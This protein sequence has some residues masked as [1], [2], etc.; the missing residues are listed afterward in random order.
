MAGV[1]KLK[2][3]FVF[4]T[5]IAIG[6]LGMWGFDSQQGIKPYVIEGYSTGTNYNG[7]AIGIAKEPGGVGEGYGIDGAF[8]REF[9]GPWHDRGTPP[10]LAYPSYG[11][12]IRMGVIDYKSTEDAFGSSVVV[13]LEVVDTEY[14]VTVAQ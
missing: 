13:W 7:E 6:V 8:W 1:L 2:W 4:L 12:K 10:S 5:G 3:L 11:Q 14:M 9:G